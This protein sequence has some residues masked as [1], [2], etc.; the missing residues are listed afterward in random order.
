LNKKLQ[1]LRLKNTKSP[2]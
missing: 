1:T 2:R